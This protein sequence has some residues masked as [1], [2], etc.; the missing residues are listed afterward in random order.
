M[1]PASEQIGRLT[2]PGW[3]LHEKRKMRKD[4]E[5][6]ASG[7]TDAWES[8][9]IRDTSEGKPRY[10]LIPT[11]PLR[12]LAMLYYRGGELY[13]DHNWANGSPCS[14][15]LSSAMRHLEQ[16]RNGEK[17]EDHWAAVIWNVMGIMHF[18]GTS[19]NDLYDWQPHERPDAKEDN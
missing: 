19:W 9:T 5:T 18:E 6:R 15:F 2:P 3:L 16:A 11:E 4:F 10:D 1:D 7:K 13:G 12:R 14:R 17:D 8:G